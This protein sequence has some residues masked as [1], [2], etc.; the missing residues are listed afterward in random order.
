MTCYGELNIYNALALHWWSSFWF[1]YFSHAYSVLFTTCATVIFEVLYLLFERLASTNL[2]NGPSYAIM[3]NCRDPFSFPWPLTWD[4]VG[5]L[6]VTKSQSVHE[7]N[8]RGWLDAY[9]DPCR[10][11]QLLHAGTNVPEILWMN[12]H[13]NMAVATLAQ[14]WVFG[15]HVY[16]QRSCCICGYSNKCTSEMSSCSLH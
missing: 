16:L 10:L 2:H 11:L 5:L 12:M 1:I 15:R 7:V 8:L 3:Q 13:T 9:R 6:P 14:Q 4:G